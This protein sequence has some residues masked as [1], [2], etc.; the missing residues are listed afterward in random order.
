MASSQLLRHVHT[1]SE[2]PGCASG[3]PHWS[4]TGCQ[5]LLSSHAG[6][7]P[8]EQPSSCR[9]HL[10]H[11]CQ[12][13]TC[14]QPT[15]P[16]LRCTSRAWPLRRP[17]CCATA[18]FSAAGGT[19][20]STP[21]SRA[22]C[23]QA[24]Q[25]SALPAEHPHAADLP[26]STLYVKNLA[27]ATTDASLLR[28]FDATVSAAGGT[29]RSAAVQKRKADSKPDGKAAKAKALSAGFGFVECSTEASAKAA[30]RKLQVCCPWRQAKLGLGTSFTILLPS[31]CVP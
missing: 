13:S 16:A 3:A 4:P 5:H 17:L 7:I 8:V 30:A 2:L 28:H 26:S 19:V 18:T 10:T 12:Q 6:C 27:F 31:S 29:V 1:S 11:G 20:Q 21:C 15:C 9:L 14:T 23:M 25:D 22:F 24:A